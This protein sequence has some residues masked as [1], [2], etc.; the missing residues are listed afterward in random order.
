M[1][2]DDLGPPVVPGCQKI[3]LV[4][5]NLHPLQERLGDWDGQVIFIP[6]SPPCAHQA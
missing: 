5:R 4:S 6:F 2:R 1:E 3:G